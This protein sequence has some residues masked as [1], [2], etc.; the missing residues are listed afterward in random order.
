MFAYS[1][2][3]GM[4]VLLLYVDDIVLIVSS[5]SLLCQFIQLLKDEFSICN[6]GSLHY[7]FGVQVQQ[8]SNCLFLCQQQYALDLLKKVNMESCNP[9]DSSLST[10]HLFT[11]NSSIFSNP[12]LYR[13][14]V[15]E[16]ALKA[17]KEKHQPK[18]KITF[19]LCYTTS[20]VEI[21]KRHLVVLV[22]I[23]LK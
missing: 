9:I 2:N 5:S 11:Y 22:V 3:G 21:L 14:I 12:S 16:A 10:S 13:S 6:M 17:L 4:A 1:G 8:K 20:G 15:E 23:Y 7:F 19:L 18:S